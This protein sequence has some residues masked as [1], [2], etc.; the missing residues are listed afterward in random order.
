LLFTLVFLAILGGTGY[1]VYQRLQESGEEAE[2]EPRS[3][4]A[5]VEVAP[6]ELDAIELRRTFTG[7]LEARSRFVVAPKVGGRIEELPFDIGDPIQDGALVARLDDDEH[8]Q[9]VV[10]AEA[11]LEVARATV[12]ESTSALEIARRGVER[13]QSLH[14]RN[15]ASDAQLDTAHADR[16]SS[17]AAVAVAEAQV[18]RAQA[19][20][21]AARIRLGYTQV[22]VDWADGGAPRV[23]SERFVDQGDTVSA[24]TPLLAIVEMDPLLAIVHVTE[25]DFSRLATGQTAVLAADTYPGERFEGLVSRIAPIFRA[26]TRQARVELTVANPEHRLKPGMFVRATIVLDRA[27]EAT[28]VPFRALTRRDGQT[29][30]FVVT[31]A[32][33]AVQ[34]RPVQEGLRDGARI[35]V[36]ATPPLP[37]GRVVV[38]GQQLLEDGSPISIPAPGGS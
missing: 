28:V 18:T 8:Q 29:G 3:R 17:E 7:S 4:V 9:A 26:A 22:T 31:P 1:L 23:V 32:G 5:P 21:E 25:R 6:I 36:L 35:Q 34:W 24:N 16:L 11:D 38:L 30:I 27:A 13:V 2:P 12:T 15:L 33:D 14:E 10:Q 37:E 19:A 20:L